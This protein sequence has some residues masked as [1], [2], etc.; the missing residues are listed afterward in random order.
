MNKAEQ[1][2][3]EF[4]DDHLGRSKG[5]RIIGSISIILGAFS[6]VL[7]QTYYNNNITFLAGGIFLIIIGSLSVFL[8]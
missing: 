7:S 5:S 8:S 4:E 3:L 2:S 1:P 6:L